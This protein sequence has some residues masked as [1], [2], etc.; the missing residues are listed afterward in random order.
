MN[1][2]VHQLKKNESKLNLIVNKTLKNKS[3]SKTLIKK[4][5]N[6]RK[7]PKFGEKNTNETKSITH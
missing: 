2:I 5:Q 3:K 4:E 6:W 1:E 7:T